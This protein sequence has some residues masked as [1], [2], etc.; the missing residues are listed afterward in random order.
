MK[1]APFSAAKSDRPVHEMVNRRPA[2]RWAMMGVSLV[3]LNV[4]LAAG[5][6]VSFAQAVDTRTVINGNG[7]GGVILLNNA[8]SA[9]LA[10]VLP[11]ASDG[12][13]GSGGFDADAPISVP[14]G[15]IQG[16]SGAY[17][18]TDSIFTNF[19]TQ[20]GAGSGGGGGLGGVIFVDDGAALTIN[21]TD[22]I[23]N[24]V[25]GGTGGSD[26]SAKVGVVEIGLG[27][28][29]IP[30][31]AVTAYYF[32]PTT[33]F[34]GGNYTLDSI[35]LTAAN[36][37]IQ[38]GMRVSVPGVNGPVT[39][40]GI[41]A[42]RT[43]LSFA[44]IAAPSGMFLDLGATTS[45]AGDTARDKISFNSFLNVP[46]QNLQPYSVLYINGVDT[47]VRILAVDKSSGVLTLDGNLTNTQWTDLTTPGANLDFF[48]VTSV[49]ISQFK[50]VSGNSITFP[51][52]N[53]I[54]KPG[55]VLTG[56]E[57][58]STSVTIT[59]VNIV[60]LGG[61]VKETV[62]VTDGTPPTNLTKFDI[63]YEQVTEG[64]NTLKVSNSKL[65]A[66]MTVTGVGVPAG[67]T[68]SSINTSTGI[69]TLSN[70]LNA[71]V[72]PESLTF[73]GITGATGQTITVA[74]QVMLSG[75]TPGMLVTGDGIPDGTTVA[76]ISGTTVT[77]SIPNSGAL[78]GTVA[79]LVFGSATELGG[80]MNGIDQSVTGSDGRD[81][82]NAPWSNV[83]WGDGE[84][85]D[86]K[87]GDAAGNGTAG[88]G[89]VGGAGG[90]GSSGLQWSPEQVKAVIDA[91]LDAGFAT[92]EAAAALA[93]VPPDVAES[94]SVALQAAHAY[95]NLGFEIGK[96]TE[97]YVE[98][99]V[100]D[101]AVGGNG[102]D[103]SDGGAGTDF[104]GGGV[105]GAGGDGGDPGNRTNGDG[106]DGGD[107][108]T[109][110]DGGFGGGG[111]MG[112]AGGAHG[113][114]V[115]VADGD[116]GVGGNA[117]FGGGD[118]SNG[119][120]ENGGGGA[121]FG[122]AIFVRSGG[123]LLVTGN[124]TFTNNRAEGGSSTNGGQSGNAAGAD[125]FMMKDSTVVIRPGTTPLVGGG[126]TDNVVTFN[127]TIG[128]DS[129][130]SYDEATNA[131]GKGAD[132][133]I[134]K[135]LTVFNGKNT[136]T[137]QTIMQ[138]GVLD[139]DDG[140]GLNHYSNLNF[141][142][143]GRT[144]G[145]GTA[146]LA[147]NSYAG[148]LLTSGYFGRQ[149]GTLGPQVQWS[150]SGGFAA[151]GDDLIVNLGNLPNPL[152]LNWG[153][154]NGFFRNGATEI[155][156]AA[157]VFGSEHA[158]AKVIWMNPIDLGNK[159]RQILV[160][161]N[162]NT[163]LDDD[164]VIMSG[165][166]S[167]TGGLIV[168]E[169]GS[170][171]WDGQLFLTGQNT[172]TGDIAIRSGTLG[173]IEG[174]TLADGIN[175]DISN[176]AEFQVIGSDVTLGTISGGTG[177]TVKIEDG[178]LTIS[179]DSPNYLGLMSVFEDGGLYLVDAGNIPNATIGLAGLFDISGITAA[180]TSV[181]DLFGDGT[182]ALGTKRLAVSDA[183]G[184]TFS[185]Q[186]TGTG[187]FGVSGGTLFLDFPDSQLITANIFAETGGK[188]SLTG[189]TI[190]TTSS[191][192]SALSV[193]NGGVID[194]KDSTLITGPSQPTASVRFDELFVDTEDP[195]DNLTGNPAYIRLGD[196]VDV[197]NGGPLLVVERDTTV[198]PTALT[199]NVTFIIDN[200][201]TI[202]GDILD[203]DADRTT[204]GGSTT[205]YLGDDVHW[206]GKAVAG[207]FWALGGS[208][209][210]F[211]SGSL[212][213]NLHAATGA[214]VDLSGNVVILGRFTIDANGVVAPGSSPGTYN[215]NSMESNNGNE[216]LWIKFGQANPQPG[217]GN[218]YSQI[219]V[220]GDFGGLNGNGPG[221]LA[222][223]LQRWQSTQS[224]PLGNLAALELLRIGGTENPG[225]NVYLAERFTQ[226]GHELLLDK[227]V[228]VAV[229]NTVVAGTSVIGNPTE[230]A[231]FDNDQITVYGLRAIVQ[232]ETYGLAT[233]AGTVHQTGLETFGSFLERRGSGP[234][235]DVWGRASYVHTEVDDTIDSTQDLAYG[236]Y[237]A[238]LV[239]LGEVRGGVLGSYSAS[240]SGI[241][242]E[243]GTNTLQG[244]VF[245]GGTYGT[246]SNGSAYLDAVGQFGYGD[247]TFSPTAASQL[248]IQSYTGLAALEA[249]VRIGDDQV[250]VTPWG[251]MVYQATYFDGLKSDWVGD[252]EFTDNSSLY[253]R[254][255]VRA[256]AK[257]GGFAPYLDLG[258]SYNTEDVKTVTVDGFDLS[259]GMGGTRYEVAAGFQADV[260]DTAVIWSSLKGAYAQDS[261]TVGVVGY[262]GQAG[263]RVTW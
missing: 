169:V 16:S 163:V 217:A 259:T 152:K 149:L 41:S 123:S 168:G 148:V 68:I 192:Q 72:K 132:I 179:E 189:G 206:T 143:T 187:A 86:G 14:G 18:I 112:G 78:S 249:G 234:L 139:A 37:Y 231:Y 15:A 162:G 222:I 197:Q 174:G 55:M 241:A 39:V 80:S 104:F 175:V 229:D 58:N 225:S 109:G 240:Q 24:A 137:G 5:L 119:D 76:S 12:I 66:G 166:L 233:L 3:A 82:N 100:G 237:G 28:L 208:S 29:E 42:D 105:G 2:A 195:T 31:N 153:S 8:Q 245:S 159:N 45:A 33:T 180:G 1:S 216:T 173:I 167:G 138:G 228:N 212:L 257:F 20:G 115:S 155:D 90:N 248:T 140:W 117:G 129:R 74:D 135:G 150:G 200:G 17:T 199:G 126:V 34:S 93:S 87:N 61:G 254:G 182:I 210:H 201:Q 134:G 226:Y 120:G 69:V 127:G 193:I 219:N 92:A 118:G 111:G 246:W 91:G 85:K 262:Q 213:D 151:A 84:G 4:G 244:N 224:T 43:T 108:G 260:S 232:D 250:S 215:P 223:T 50:G 11:D 177:S 202:S 125:L 157:L 238:D 116:G 165:A 227:R 32:D 49:E 160:T 236:Q 65:F 214:Q 81:G 19:T 107:G 83:L 21:N 73:S 53:A 71:G 114:G 261:D 30:V 181:A 230:D 188:L 52:E 258:M 98:Y 171:F 38:P 47:G 221:V 79:N 247:W 203:E 36:R 60:D 204:P 9:N 145:S 252:A 6:T 144:G 40:T 156:D 51:G 57:F 101:N 243:T 94:V 54:F 103:G 88:V 106:G 113:A 142:G 64:G 164:Y 13:L 209:A 97:W 146:S 235:E 158:D 136:Y 59:A 25:V 194:V 63:K 256:E 141:Q 62:I 253:L 26:P 255:G 95:V 102:G 251:Q 170:S 178:T 130:E 263:M 207:D 131:R 44:P 133:N 196:G 186:I 185:G 176:G 184:G 96:L 99:A 89:G 27:D 22:F 190:N 7:G 56:G 67:T 147:E 183:Q 211:N 23:R 10:G 172:F 75:V 198:N 239:N 205:V 218:D 154:T 121:G 122:G 124:S 77:L 220:A 70:N 161:E 35:E 128:D 191:S 48:N 110:G 242:T 46:L